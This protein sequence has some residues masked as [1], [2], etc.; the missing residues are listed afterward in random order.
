M[1]NRESDSSATLRAVYGATYNVPSRSILI[2]WSFLGSAHD[3][4]DGLDSG[5]YLANS[6]V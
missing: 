1:A 5:V 6:L 4:S 2:A 3:T